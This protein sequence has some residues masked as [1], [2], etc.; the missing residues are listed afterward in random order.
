MD[1]FVEL[2]KLAPMVKQ[3]GFQDVYVDQTNTEMGLWKE[4]EKENADGF[5]DV[6]RENAGVHTGKPE[7]DYLKD[8]DM[9]ELCA[10]VVVSGRK[11]GATITVA[12]NGQAVLTVFNKS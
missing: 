6:K 9:N 8:M 3:Q 2:E 4:D 10:R 7:Y 1:M 12:Q 5:V 11:P